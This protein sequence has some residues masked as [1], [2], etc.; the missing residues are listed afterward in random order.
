MASPVNASRLTSRAAA[1]HSGPKPLAKRY[2]VK[3]LHLLSF[4]SLSWHTRLGV[5]LRRESSRLTVRF[6]PPICHSG[7]NLR[8]MAASG[9]ISAGGASAEMC[10]KPPPAD[11]IGLM[12]GR[13]AGFDCKRSEYVQIM[14]FAEI[15]EVC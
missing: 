13:F 7:R 2:F 14:H 5:N 11:S 8:G 1:H 9:R 15:R 12:L 4:A 3:D 6:A 10:Q